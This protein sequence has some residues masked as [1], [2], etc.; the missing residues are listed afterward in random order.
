MDFEVTNRIQAGR[1]ERSE[2]RQ[3]GMGIRNDRCTRGL[4]TLELQVPKLR[5]GGVISSF[6]NRATRGTGT[7]GG[8]PEAWIGGMST[9]SRDWF[10]RS[11]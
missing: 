5:Q 9:Q 10:K 6:W 11:A 3:T 7:D 1:H 4:G 2:A 8:H